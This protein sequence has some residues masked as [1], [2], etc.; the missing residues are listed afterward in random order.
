MKI[1]GEDRPLHDQIFSHIG[2]ENPPPC[3]LRN[4]A[5][6]KYEFLEEA[7]EDSE[8][9][10]RLRRDFFKN[11]EK[12]WN[13]MWKLLDHFMD[14]EDFIGL[15]RRADTTR[16]WHRSKLS[17]WEIPYIF[18]VWKEWKPVKKRDGTILRETWIRFW[19]DAHVR[20]IE[21]IWIR[22]QGNPRIIKAW[23]KDPKRG[24]ILG[25]DHLIDT[26]E[27]RINLDFLAMPHKVPADFVVNKMR[28]SFLEDFSP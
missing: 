16:L 5:D 24:A 4:S 15:I 22:T 1:V 2:K 25:P 3:P 27:V 26:D 18:L 23:Y 20:T 14:I 6:Y 19:F 21:D 17:E 11:W 10:R 12:H 9:G 13:V 28:Q 7:P 8:E